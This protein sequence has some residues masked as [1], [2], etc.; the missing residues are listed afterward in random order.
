MFELTDVSKRYG[1]LA[2]VDRLDLSL[3]AGRTTVL[4]GPS[5]CGKSTILRMMI[6]LLAP[7]AGQLRFG[8]EL[9]NRERLGGLR[10]RMGYVIQ[11]GGLFPHLSAREN[12]ALM[13]RYLGWPPEQVA[14][15]IADLADLT[16]FPGDALDRYPAQLSGGQK[17]RVSLMRALMLDPEALLLDEPLG[18]LDPMIRFDL[19]RD[20]KEV[21]G[22]LGKTVVMVTHDLAEAVYFGD[23]I[24]LLR[25]GRI[26]QRGTLAEMIERPADEFVLRFIQ[27]QRSLHVAEGAVP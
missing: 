5:G 27:A 6:G 12:I 14:V 24:V 26:V 15:R 25:A 11:D 4:I 7:D 2:V 1:T 17:Q 18:A 22:R 10:R 3:E 9:V 23:T 16:H 13:A 8:G 19:Q 20:L 21:F